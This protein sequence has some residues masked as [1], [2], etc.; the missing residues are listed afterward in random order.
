VVENGTNEKSGYGFKK[1]HANHHQNCSGHPNP[2]RID[3]SQQP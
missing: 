2:V 1:P 3:V